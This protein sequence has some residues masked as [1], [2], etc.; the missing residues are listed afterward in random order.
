MNELLVAMVPV[1]VAIIGTV[2]AFL[3]KLLIAKTGKVNLEKGI[4]SAGI[5]V[6]A[7]EQI[8][9]AWGLDAAEK[10]DQAV[11]YMRAALKNKLPAEVVDALIE[12]AVKA[13]KDASAEIKDAE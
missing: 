4:D 1:L 5:A 13:M 9:A 7:V 10:K 8:A 12:S 11:A 2:G 3:T 6:D